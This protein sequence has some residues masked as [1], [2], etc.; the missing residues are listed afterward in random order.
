VVVVHSGQQR[1]LAESAYAERRTQVEHA[2]AAIGMPLRAALPADADRLRD[3]LAR[4][5]GRHVITENRRV[6]S[7]AAA[8]SAGDLATAGALMNESHRS[9]AEDFDVSTPALDALVDAL[10]STSGVYGARLTGAGF[11]G[12]A[13][14]LV[15]AGAGARLG[16]LV[17]ASDGA[18][19][20]VA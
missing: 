7:A 5:R 12:C 14:A 15:E 11:G 20:D 2:A 6:E 1:A 3:P 10:Q 13:V 9:L 18:T 16:W 8:L 19:V 4:R 17:R